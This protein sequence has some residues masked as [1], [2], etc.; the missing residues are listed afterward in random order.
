MSKTLR[1]ISI[2]LE[3]WKTAQTLFDNMSGEIEK[4]LQAAI[5]IRSEN[6]EEKTPKELKKLIEGQEEI[7]SVLKCNHNK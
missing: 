3:T 7:I 6:K 5:K 2:D 1:T 4:L